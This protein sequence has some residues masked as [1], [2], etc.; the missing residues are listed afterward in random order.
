MPNMIKV[1]SPV[2]TLLTSGS[3]EEAAAQDDLSPSVSQMV[4]K[5]ED[6]G[7]PKKELDECKDDSRAS[8]SSA[9]SSPARMSKEGSPN[10]SSSGGVSYDNFL[11]V[12]GLS[13]KSIITP[14]RM[15]TNHRNVTRPK[16]IKLRSKGKTAGV[17]ERCIPPQVVGPTV[18]YWTEPYL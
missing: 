15:M 2:A 17:I 16:D 1:A 4:R 8:A 12:T 14:S 3:A 13:Q 6:L 11:E 9:E 5:F 18:K 7:T 10:S